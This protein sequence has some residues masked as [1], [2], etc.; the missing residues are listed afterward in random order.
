LTRL[1]DLLYERSS[2]ANGDLSTNEAARVRVFQDVS[3]SVAHISTALVQP[4][5]DKRSFDRCRL[6]VRVG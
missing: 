3:P 2:E 4:M 5:R 1:L 6:G